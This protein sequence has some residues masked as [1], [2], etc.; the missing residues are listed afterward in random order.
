VA[1][2]HARN[3]GH[4]DQVVEFPRIT[5][6]QVDLGDLTVGRT[7]ME[8]GWR[9]STDVRPTV[10][11][12]WCQ[13]RHVGVVT[14]GRFG[15]VFPDGASREFGPDD[16]FE[17]PPGHDGY[18]IGDEPCVSIEWTGVRTFTGFRTGVGARVLATLLFTDIVGSTALAARLGDRP[19]RDLLSAHFEAARS[20]IE[21]RRG[22]EVATTG[23]G[24]L[25]RFESPADALHCAAA[26]GKR[27]T[28]AGLEIR[29]GVH[30]GEVELVGSDVRGVAVHEAARVL[31]AALPREI[32]ASETAKV[33]SAASGLRFEDRGAFTLKG[34]S[35]ERQLYA[36][37]EDGET[38]G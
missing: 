22:V 8:P 21:R 31:A 11:G 32:L 2:A 33:L 26:I 13:A 37:L 34:L 38:T 1:E 18:V 4:P 25:A 16:V 28:A 5:V 14:S 10:G 6:E 23:D 19:W 20:E 3:L 30:V 27:A 36:Y 29:A 24:M 12:E 17:V 35:G 15:V 7:T 9:W